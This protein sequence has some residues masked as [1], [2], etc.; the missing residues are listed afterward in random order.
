VVVLHGARQVGKTTLARSLAAEIGATYATLDNTDQLD[1][2]RADPPT[3]ISTAGTPLVIDEVQRVGDPL[4]LAI[5]AQVDQDDRLGQF[6]VTGSTVEPRRII[7]HGWRR[8]SSSTASPPGAATS[9]RR[10]S[11]DLRST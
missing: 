11:N 8:S 2:A 7:C 6:L 5:K 9:S 3:F 10:W 1:V 4:V